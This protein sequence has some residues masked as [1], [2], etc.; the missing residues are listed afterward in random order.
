MHGEEGED[1]M[2]IQ[3]RTLNRGSGRDRSGS[4]WTREK[5]SESRLSLKAC[6]ATGG[7]FGIVDASRTEVGFYV[8][9]YYYL[10]VFANVVI[11]SRVASPQ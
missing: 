10:I 2:A 4:Q 3:G 9:S 6:L 11:I 8:G 5:R 1:R 7:V